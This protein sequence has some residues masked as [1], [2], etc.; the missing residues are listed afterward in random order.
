MIMDTTLKVLWYL[1]K[2]TVN[3]VPA[4]AKNVNFFFLGYCLSKVFEILLD[5]T[6][7]QTF[8]VHSG[9]THLDPYLGSQNS[10]KNKRLFSCFE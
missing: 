9:F 10:L 5:D 3:M 8:H 2:D 7:Y 6:L 4:L 1:F